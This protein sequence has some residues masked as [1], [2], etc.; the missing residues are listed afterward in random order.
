MRRR[1]L[2]RKASMRRFRK[3]ARSHVKNLRSRVPRGGIRA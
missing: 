3:G 2:S 1:R